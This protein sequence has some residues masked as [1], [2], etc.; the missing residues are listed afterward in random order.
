VLYTFAGVQAGMES[1]DLQGA[2]THYLAALKL[3]EARGMRPLAVRCLLGLAR[4][5]ELAGEA[6]SAGSYGGRA[7]RLASDLGMSLASL[8]PA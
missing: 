6:T 1:P 5:H 4:V 7:N 2:K 3:A 8:G